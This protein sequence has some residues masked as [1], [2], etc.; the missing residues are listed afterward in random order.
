MK[1][2]LVF[3]FMALLLCS[4]A[5]L[6]AV[7]STAALVILAAMG[8]N[9]NYT[10]N[11]AYQT[12]TAGI[13]EVAAFS[14]AQRYASR[15]LGG[16]TDDLIDAY[17]GTRVFSSSFR[18]SRVFYTIEDDNGHLLETTVP[19]R[20]D[21]TAYVVKIPSVRYM[22]VLSQ[23]KPVHSITV[24]DEAMPEM[25]EEAAEEAMSSMDSAGQR[26]AS[27]YSYTDEDGGDVTYYYVRENSPKLI[28]TLYLAPYALV[29]DQ[30]W[31]TL[32][33][34]WNFRAQLIILL[35]VCMLLI[36]ISAVYLCTVAGRSPGSDG[37]EPAGLNRMPIDLYFLLAGSLI[38]AMAAAIL[39][40]GEYL[41]SRDFG[42]M[43]ACML[44]G[45]YAACLA[46]VGFCYCLVTQ[47]KTPD[48]Y[49]WH[50]SITGRLCSAAGKCLGWLWCNL[51]HA[52]AVFIKGSIHL[53]VRIFRA[54]GI[55][56][57]WLGIQLKRPIVFGWEKLH[58]LL[59]LLPL[60]W[61]WLLVAA[62]M[63][64]AMLLMLVLEWGFGMF[65]TVAG[66]I[67]VVFYGA[68]AFGTLLEGAQRMRSG[69]LDSKIDDKLMVGG[70]RDF[71]AELNGLADV[72]VVAAQKQLKSERMKTELITNVSH[73]IKTPLT[74]IIN[75]VDLLEKPHTEE[76]Q[77]QY[78][79]VLHRQS[80]RMKKLIDDLMEMSKAASGNMTV[81][82]IE[83][84]AAEAVNQAIGEFADK[85][86]KADLTPVFHHPE[87]TI[88]LLAD[89][90]LMWRAM[91]NVLSNA[92]KYAL[93]GTRL[94]IDLSETEKSAVISFKNISREQLNISAD[95]LLER[96]VRGDTSRNTEG[97]GLGLNIAK[98]LME[99]Q[100]GSLQL[101]VDGD[102][103]KVTLIFPL[104]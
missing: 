94:Y 39:Q 74:S 44:Y 100:H 97:S 98:S 86:E 58:G 16:C 72:A 26:A 102:L 15:A 29:S 35:G 53:I 32:R 34:A 5:L 83:M 10:V 24:P 43:M 56:L 61:Q 87:K 37:I 76:Q 60:T 82:I 104:A 13:Y 91:S 66:C 93:P 65:L 99:L 77:K 42:V 64:A 1:N 31:N 40:M 7:T 36:G 84:D 33:I 50:N 14:V 8:I 3:K 11:D 81:E 38:T 78:L 48:R 28:V 59:H 46:F 85:L 67:A 96:F 23:E 22:K 2:H 21:L 80:L 51:P 49:A 70:Y 6:G 20:D 18:Q 62:M 68:W 90:R 52:V 27:A 9:D 17:F 41:A 103:F 55:F 19:D 79:D 101:L 73:D 30:G 47:I 57:Q 95:E 12:E 25:A 45:S 63:A 75:Y 69:S 92:V 54:G 88:N 71:A 4:L 89:G